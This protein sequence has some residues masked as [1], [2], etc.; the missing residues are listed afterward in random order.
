MNITIKSQNFGKFIKS[1]SIILILI[2]LSIRFI[3]WCQICIF[4]KIYWP[5]K[6]KNKKKMKFL[7]G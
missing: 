6:V 4:C 1:S 7:D 2:T 3:L 5:E